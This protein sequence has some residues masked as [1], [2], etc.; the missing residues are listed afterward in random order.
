VAE[1]ST[2]L[3]AAEEAGIYIPTMCFYKD[4]EKFT[5]CMICLVR[6][7]QSG[8]LLPGCSSEVKQGMDIVTE[9]EQI[10]ESRKTA[11]E[12][13]LSEHVGDCEAPCQI[14]CPAHMD[15][16]LM[17]RLLASEKISE[18]LH[19][20]KRDIALPAV[21][22]R[23]CPAPCEGACKRKPID[24]AVSICLLKRYAGDFGSIDE[25]QPLPALRNEQ[26]AI[27][28]SGPAGLA[29]AYYLMQKGIR[30][31]IYDKNEKP[32]GMLRYGVPDEKL[33]KE[34]LD[35]EIDIIL[36]TGIGIHQNHEIT[37]KDF[38]N[39][40]KE[41]DAVVLATGDISDEVK[42]WG[43]DANEKQVIAD[44]QS[45]QTNIENVFAV[46]NVNRHTKLAIRSLGQGKEVAF[47]IEQFLDSKKVQ[48]EP[49]KFNARFGKLLND[50]YPQY[51]KESVDIERINPEEG[52]QAGFSLNEVIREAARCMHCD[53]RKIDN[54]KLRDLS[55]EYAANQRKYRDGER[56]NIT[57]IVHPA[58]IYEPQKCIKCGICVRITEKHKE[59]FGLTFIGRGFDVQIGI[60]F[61]KDLNEALT[62]TAKIVADAC[63]TGAL[64]RK[65]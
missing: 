1:G 4:L 31:V 58:I 63:P 55:E 28:G 24:G 42:T 30:S 65:N 54:C 49:M 57:K 7:N 29:A 18:A 10:N 12:L 50:E 6:D 15:I 14:A 23:I 34:V 45:Y 64:A 52:E 33:E 43:P 11:L 40:T 47:S 22:G 16:P 51:L 60:P 3:S 38:E 32:G 61:N 2:I 62:N 41:Y 36:Q 19:I 39:L 8:K 13:M 56:K 44:K 37:K 5:S 59:K 35:K 25:H 46:G 26:V 17:N 9:D 27:I 53:C 20:V 48:G 21:L